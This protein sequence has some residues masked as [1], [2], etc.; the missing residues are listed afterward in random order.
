M[1]LDK[2]LNGVLDQGNGCLIV[3]DEPEEDVS[4]NAPSP[5]ILPDM[6][7][8]AHL[9]NARLDLVPDGNTSHS[10]DR[11]GGRCAVCQGICSTLLRE[12]RG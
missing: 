11:Q 2:I 5:S 9:I 10:P 1:I 3:F 4:T 12:W 7:Q 6:F 8:S